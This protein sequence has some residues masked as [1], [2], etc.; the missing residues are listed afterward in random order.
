VRYGDTLTAIAWK[1]GVTTWE[2]AQWNKL[3]NPNYI[4]AGMVLKVCPPL[5]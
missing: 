4:Y 3:A 2:L 5:Y 1:F